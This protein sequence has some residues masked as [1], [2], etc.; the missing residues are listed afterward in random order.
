MQKHEANIF[1]F[2]EELAGL[3]Q[4]LVWCTLPSPSLFPLPL[5]IANL[6]PAPAPPRPS[7]DRRTYS[8]RLSHLP[9]LGDFFPAQQAA[10]LNATPEHCASI[11]F[12]LASSLFYPS[13]IITTRSTSGLSIMFGETGRRTTRRPPPPP[14]PF[15]LYR[16]LA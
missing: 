3:R 1:Y 13:L 12:D 8:T 2:D 15:P 16:F 14:C 7:C 5:L 4:P 6:S 9:S 10:E 11:T